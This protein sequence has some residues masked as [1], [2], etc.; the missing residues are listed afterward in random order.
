[1]NI[2]KL[3]KP[4]LLI[5]VIILLCS[6]LTR[7]FSG[8]DTLLEYAEKNPELAYPHGEPEQPQEDN[9]IEGETP[10]NHE[11]AGTA[12]PAKSRATALP[13]NRKQKLNLTI[14]MLTEPEQKQLLIQMPKT[15]RKE[16]NI[17]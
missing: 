7:L 14:P 13:G 8:S 1:M 2:D 12:P 16:R 4:L 3:W 5:V 9:I 11:S 17:L 15:I 10:S 6:V